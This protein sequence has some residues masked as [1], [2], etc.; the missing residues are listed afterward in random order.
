[1]DGAPEAGARHHGTWWR[2]PAAL[3]VIVTCAVAACDA[4]TVP[5]SPSPEISMPSDF[6]LT[7]SAFEPG[8]AIPS[9][10][11]CDGQNVSPALAWEGAPDETRA[12]VLVVDDPDADGFVHW[13]VYDMTGS[14]SG[15]LPS[16]VSA[17]PDA[18]QQGTNDFGEIGWGGPCP[19][20]GEHRYRFR[21]YALMEPLELM[22]P[23]DGAAIREA[24]D[25]A[26]VVAVAELEGSY[27]RTG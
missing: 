18:P 8:G 21:L 1:M 4:G 17:S 3:L 15:A 23:P 25:A 24:L 9:L 2:R 20:S 10:H 27:R 12:F 6:R 22:T 7:S 11:S 14:D 26:R 5:T 16:A 19:P 13:I